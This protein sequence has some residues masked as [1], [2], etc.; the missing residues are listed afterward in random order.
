M[1]HNLMQLG[2]CICVRSCA[3]HS[4]NNCTA[5]LHVLWPNSVSTLVVQTTRVVH[6][7]APVPFC[8]HELHDVRFR[9]LDSISIIILSA[10]LL[11]GAAYAKTT[12]FQPLF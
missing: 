12:R 10:S 3:L 7:E 9:L 4:S 1:L 5:N 6:V 11:R 2:G 8:N